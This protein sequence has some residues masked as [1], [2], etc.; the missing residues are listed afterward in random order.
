MCGVLQGVQRLGFGFDDV[1]R[2]VN[3]DRLKMR[4]AISSD[5]VS[6]PLRILPGLVI[7]GINATLH[8]PQN[9][10]THCVSFLFPPRV[11]G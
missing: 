7:A 1:A 9:P 8:F 11:G 3:L 10:F 6:D 4:P 5:A 2:V